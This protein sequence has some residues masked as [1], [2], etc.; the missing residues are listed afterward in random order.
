MTYGHTGHVRAGSFTP[1]VAEFDGDG[2]PVTLSQRGQ[3][4][5]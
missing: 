3:K 1:G 4:K 2:Y 5:P